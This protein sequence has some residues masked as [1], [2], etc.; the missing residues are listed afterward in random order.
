MNS[1]KPEAL[2]DEELENVA[3]GMAAD[4]GTG[5]RFYNLNQTIAKGEH[6]TA[7]LTCDHCKQQVVMDRYVYTYYGV[8]GPDS[9]LHERA[10]I[11]RNCRIISEWGNSGKIGKSGGC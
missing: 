2:T 9:V 1:K 4:V 11:C 5:R 8:N 7:V 3:A 10:Q 6:S